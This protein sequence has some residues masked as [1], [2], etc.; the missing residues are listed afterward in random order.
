MRKP[1]TTFIYSCF[2]AVFIL[3][4]VSLFW[5][6]P[7]WLTL[8][9]IIISATMIAIG[10]NKKDLYLYIICFF[11]GPL[12]EAIAISFG[13]WAYTSPN[14]IGIPIWLPF[15]WGNAAVFIKRIYRLIDIVN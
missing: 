14:I 6:S 15:V 12:S 2:L 8:I 9:L 11:A 10:K 7:L 1:F 3:F 13:I 5:Q 4:S